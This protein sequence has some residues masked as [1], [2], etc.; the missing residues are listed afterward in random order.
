MSRSPRRTRHRAWG[1]GPGV[2]PAPTRAVYRLGDI[3]EVRLG[4]QM[5][6][7]IAE[8]DGQGEVVGGIVLMRPGENALETIAAVKAR[9]AELKQGLPE[10]VELVAVYDR[11]GLIHRAIDTLTSR[12]VEEF[13]HRRPGVRALPVASALGAGGDPEPAGRA[14]RGLYRH[15]VAGDQRQHHVARGASPLR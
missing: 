10:G 6:E 9:L 15:A 8:L 2:D 12:L 3:A 14:P 5:R 1:P 13:A 7:G 11:S 4:P